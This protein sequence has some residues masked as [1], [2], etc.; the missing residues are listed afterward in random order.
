MVLR[1][2]VCMKGGWPVLA[3]WMGLGKVGM[4]RCDPGMGEEKQRHHM[5]SAAGRSLAG[6]TS[7]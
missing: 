7:P 1:G 6:P 5:V 2:L 4:N 3:L